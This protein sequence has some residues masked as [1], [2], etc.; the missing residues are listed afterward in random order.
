MSVVWHKKVPADSDGIAIEL[1]DVLPWGL[2]TLREFVSA[3]D[4]ERRLPLGDD[5]VLLTV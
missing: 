4:D 2:A 5:S 3:L 1:P